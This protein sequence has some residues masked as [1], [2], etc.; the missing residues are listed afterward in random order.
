ML[1]AHNDDSKKTRHLHRNG[2]RWT[3]DTRQ[4]LGVKIKGAGQFECFPDNDQHESCVPARHTVVRAVRDTGAHTG[5]HKHTQAVRPG[6]HQG[7]G[8]H[9]RRVQVEE[10]HGGRGHFVTQ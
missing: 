1:K 10:N 2:Q 9:L 7:G 6:L 3:L 8:V 5:Q 4:H